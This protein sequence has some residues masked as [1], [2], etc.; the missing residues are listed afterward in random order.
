[1]GPLLQRLSLGMPQE[2]DSGSYWP[3]KKQFPDKA[4]PDLSL[5]P[6]LSVRKEQTCSVCE[7]PRLTSLFSFPTALCFLLAPHWKYQ[8]SIVGAALVGFLSRQ[9]Q[10][11]PAIPPG[12]P[13][14]P[15]QPR[16]HGKGLGRQNQRG[17]PL[18]GVTFWIRSCPGDKPE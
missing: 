3:W 6:V 1:M 2:Q 5:C 12:A 14:G 10:D 13:R 15:R 16:E 9:E 18:A 7:K 11:M 4:S 8:D 17:N